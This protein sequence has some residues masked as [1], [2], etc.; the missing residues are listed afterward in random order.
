M[1]AVNLSSSSFFVPDMLSRAYLNYGVALSEASLTFWL[2]IIVPFSYLNNNNKVV[3]TI[4][5]L[6]FLTITSMVMDTIISDN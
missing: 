3:F 4:K 6:V 2:M 5:L 1:Q